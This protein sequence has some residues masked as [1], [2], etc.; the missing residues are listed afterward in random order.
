MD[1]GDGEILPPP[2]GAV[3][4]DVPVGYFDDWVKGVRTNAMPDKEEVET[5]VRAVR[6]LSKLNR[7]SGHNTVAEL[8]ER[9]CALI[10]R[11]AVAAGIIP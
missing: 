5:V 9:L 6:V 3:A 4:G 8:H 1:T 11:L 7:E 2:P 10:E